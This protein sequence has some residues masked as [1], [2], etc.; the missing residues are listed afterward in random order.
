MRDGI[1]DL[2]KVLQ[3]VLYLIV[4]WIQAEIAYKLE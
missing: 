4:Y 3:W 1:Y 2:S